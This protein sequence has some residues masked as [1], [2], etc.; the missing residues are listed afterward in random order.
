MGKQVVQWGHL[1]ILGP[2]WGAVCA[3]KSLRPLCSLV[4]VVLP[5]P[6]TQGS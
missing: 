1:L 6:H 5:H 4:S 3:E 2:S